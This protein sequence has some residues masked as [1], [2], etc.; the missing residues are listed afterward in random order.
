[1]KDEE[2]EQQVLR[3]YKESKSDRQLSD[4]LR[5]ILKERVSEKMKEEAK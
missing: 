5:A 2:V 1:M 4:A 3:A